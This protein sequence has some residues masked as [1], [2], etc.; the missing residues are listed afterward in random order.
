MK[1]KASRNNYLTV[2]EMFAR[3]D[4]ER[5]ALREHCSSLRAESIALIKSE[6]NDHCDSLEQKHVYSEFDTN[7]ADDSLV[8]H[9]R[10][11]AVTQMDLFAEELAVS[12]SKQMSQIE[13][14]LRSLQ[15]E[16]QT[17]SQCLAE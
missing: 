7:F 14:R 4:E 3:D 10:S 1:K 11:E 16:E 9:A 15:F 5:M 13:Q 12:G 8:L 2:Q 17:V 6:R